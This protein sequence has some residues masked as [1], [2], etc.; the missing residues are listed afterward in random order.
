MF[1]LLN[2][3]F[4]LFVFSFIIADNH[5]VLSPKVFSLFISLLSNNALLMFDIFNF[6]LAEREFSVEILDL[7]L[8]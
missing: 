5:G 2:F 1:K 7:I 8:F 3:F 4:K 6:A